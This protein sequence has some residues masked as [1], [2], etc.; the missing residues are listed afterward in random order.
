[1]PAPVT[2]AYRALR[3]RLA[4]GGG[5]SADG[6]QTPREWLGAVLASGRFGHAEEALSA[7]I[8]AYERERFGPGTA[9]RWREALA[10]LEAALAAGAER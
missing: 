10:R 6:Q 1:R 5:P 8:T 9:G 2:L 4:R 3:R 7:F